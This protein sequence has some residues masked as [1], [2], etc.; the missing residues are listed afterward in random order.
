MPQTLPRQCV[1]R[2]ASWY[3]SSRPTRRPSCRGPARG[4]RVESS[5]AQRLG[6]NRGSRRPC[7]ALAAGEPLSE[8][9]Q[10]GARAGCAASGGAREAVAPPK[11]ARPLL[12]RSAAPQISVSRGRSEG[13]V[14]IPRLPA[15]EQVHNGRRAEEAT[16]VASAR[17]LLAKVQWSVGSVR[18]VVARARARPPGLSGGWAESGVFRA[19]WRSC[20]RGLVRTRCCSVINDGLVL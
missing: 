10:T 11:P 2:G 18:V 8:S 4:S 3:F 16:S 13:A 14:L 20:S 6:Q 1:R 7:E 19:C 15:A 9:M 5:G 12:R 17:A